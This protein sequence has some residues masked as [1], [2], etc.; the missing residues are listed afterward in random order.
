MDIVYRNLN[1]PKLE[2]FYILQ[3][4]YDSFPELINQF[5]NF[6]TEVNN[7]KFLGF[8]NISDGPVNS[9][10]KSAILATLPKKNYTDC[11]FVDQF[12]FVVLWDDI[13]W[14][15]LET[16]NNLIKNKLWSDKFSTEN[17]REMIGLIR[18][19]QS[20]PLRNFGNY[21]FK[22]MTS[23][24][25]I[26]AKIPVPV[27]IP[28][29]Y[30]KGHYYGHSG[31][32]ARWFSYFDLSFRLKFLKVLKNLSDDASKSTFKCLAFGKPQEIWE[33]YF[34]K[35]KSPP[36]YLDYIKLDSNSVIINCGVERGNELPAFLS[37]GSKIYSIDPDGDARLC[38]YSQAWKTLY[39]N[40]LVF[41]NKWLYTSGDKNQK[42]ATLK[43]IT[44]ELN[45]DRIDLIK[46]DI[47]GAER[48]MVDD[49]VEIAKKHRPQIAISIYHTQN[50]D[51]AASP[52]RDLVG[53]PLGLIKKLTNYSFHIGFYS[54]ERWEIILY[55]I[56]KEKA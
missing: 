50:D 5:I 4:E 13:I 1:L 38:N 26:L 30:H 53:I 51:K 6:M 34:N 35:I 2:E 40:R 31:G 42:P 44:N 22:R 49:L 23:H 28:M 39:Q 41:I 8:V 32:Y 10:K 54:Y 19:K 7:S 45:L 47:E 14:G 20:A 48:F 33:Y 25:G 11:K 36:Q 29:N 18:G 3:N 21:L 15:K 43:E 17:F 16:V 24:E 46:V 37:Y 27:K 9:Q 52:L 12:L 56:P 55:C